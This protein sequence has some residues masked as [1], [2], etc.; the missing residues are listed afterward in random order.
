MKKTVLSAVVFLAVGV[1]H[2]APAP[3]EDLNYGNSDQ[4]IERLE[5]IIKAKQ[6]SD[7]AMQ[8]QMDSLQRDVLDLRG[9]VEQQTYQMTQMLQRQR[10][11]YDEIAQ[12]TNNHTDSLPSSSEITVTPQATDN[13]Q[14]TSLDETSSYENAV[15]LVLK[16]RQY[17]RAIPAFEAFIKQY[18]ES[19]YAANAYYWLGQLLYNDGQYQAAQKAFIDVVDR[20]KDSGKRADSMVKLG[21]IYEKLKDF[22]SA[23]RYYKQVVKEYSNSSAARIASQQLSSM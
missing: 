10:Q 14:L 15:N 8:N 23:K 22:P 20:Y 21:L 9:L 12:L 2:A 18:P 17:E 3:V 5:R 6:Q 1:V 19:S 4:R 13:S 7:F 16:Q 11:L